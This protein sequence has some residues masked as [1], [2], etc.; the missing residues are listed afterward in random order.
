MVDSRSLPAFGHP[1]YPQGDVRARAL[2]DSVKLPKRYAQ[3]RIAAE[4]MTGELPNVDFALAAVTTAARLPEDASM[5]IFAL[6]RSVGWMAH[7]LEQT[8][9]GKL[10]RPR[11]RYSGP[12]LQPPGRAATASTPCSACR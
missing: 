3:I 11:A 8:Q 4:E 5:V 12:A 2:L 9:A 10:I 6:A 7:A 1:L